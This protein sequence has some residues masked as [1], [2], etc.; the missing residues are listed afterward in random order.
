MKYL[1][2]YNSLNDVSREK[3]IKAIIE[4]CLVDLEPSLA[5]EF[6]EI[7]ELHSIQAKVAELQKVV[8]LKQQVIDLEQEGKDLENAK[9][10]LGV[11]NKYKYMVKIG[12]AHV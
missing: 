2:E 11:I 4:N 12:R 6:R 5:D 3:R 10:N 1:E 8:D 7:N 9:D